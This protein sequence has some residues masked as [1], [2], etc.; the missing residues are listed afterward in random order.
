M[1]VAL[2]R[3]AIGDAIEVEVAGGIRTCEDALVNALGR[4][5]SEGRDCDVYLNRESMKR[6]VLISAA[7]IP[8]LCC[9]FA[10][11]CSSTPEAQGTPPPS[12]PN[13]QQTPPQ[14]E[15]E[16]KTDTVHA[17]KSKTGEPTRANNSEPQ[18]KYMV[19]IGAFK[20]PHNASRVQVSARDRYHMPVVNDF[21][22]MRGLYQIRIGFFESENTARAFCEQLQKDF[23]NDYKDCWV[24]QLRR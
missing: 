4:R 10:G 6:E 11:G 5:R 16:T 1:L 17:L 20:D 14:M 21:D 12:P 3:R 24:V 7:F 13:V 2:I 22:V 15:F 18:I 19:Q 23:P 8:C 9:L